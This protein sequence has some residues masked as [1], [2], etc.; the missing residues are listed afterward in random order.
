MLVGK[1]WYFVKDMSNF[2]GRNSNYH[3]FQ[4][5]SVVDEANETAMGHIVYIS[6]YISLGITKKA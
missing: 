6:T 1:E 2:D 5:S 4:T 3:D